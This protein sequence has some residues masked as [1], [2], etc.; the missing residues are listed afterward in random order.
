MVPFTTINR[1]HVADNTMLRAGH[2][3]EVRG[4]PNQAGSAT[5][6]LKFLVTATVSTTKVNVQAMED[7]STVAFSGSAAD[8]VGLEVVVIGNSATE[9]QTGASL[10]PW[11]IPLDI[12]NY[13]QIWRTAF[14][15][16]GTVLKAGLKFDKTG[17]YAD[18]AK[19]ATLQHAIE[20]ELGFLFG[21]RTLST[22][23]VTGLPRRTTG[24]IEW[25]LKQWEL[26]NT[27]NGGAFNYRPGGSAATADT[28]DNKRIINNSTGTMSLK[29]YH[30]YLE[31]L[32]RVTNNVA[33]E[34]LVFCGTGFLQVIHD[35]Y[36]GKATLNVN[37]PVKNQWGWDIVSHATPFG[38]VHYKTHPLF[39]QN[40]TL[41]NSALFLD[42]NNL[43]YR[44]LDGRD[45]TLLKMVQPNNA[46]YREDE[47][48]GESG[49][50]VRYPESHMFIKNVLTATP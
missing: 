47:W 41:R 20:M 4:W 8:T 50:E 25:F 2:I 40:A 5:Y 30:N 32:F 27:T 37:V 24:G 45:T 16:T 43:I 6:N 26:G 7:M 3:L 23:S 42:V 29:Q 11:N 35:L 13:T 33:Q 12:V 18:K 46:D 21:T 17:P 19:D 36:L 28:D 49:L 48:R 15:F 10:A 34:K 44:A 22:D 39:S 14:Q 1:L 38:T 9:G 31:R